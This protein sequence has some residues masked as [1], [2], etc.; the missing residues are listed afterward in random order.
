LRRLESDERR[1]RIG[2]RALREL[3]GGEMACYCVESGDAGEETW[4]SWALGVLEERGAALREELEGTE[5]EQELE[6]KLVAAGE[7]LRGEIGAWEEGLKSGENGDGNS[8]PEVDAPED[9]I[10]G[11]WVSVIEG[12]MESLRSALTDVAEMGSGTEKVSNQLTEV[13]GRDPGVPDFTSSV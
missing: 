13:F 3:F 1:E 8:L 6:E 5:R 12:L 2:E 4:V 10:E 11:Y 7:F 9:E